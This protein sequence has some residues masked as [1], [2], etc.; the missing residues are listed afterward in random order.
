MEITEPTHGSGAEGADA[1]GAT[2]SLS[3]LLTTMCR[4]LTSDELKNHGG[5]GPEVTGGGVLCA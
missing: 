5:N 4:E 3:R 2:A 1:P